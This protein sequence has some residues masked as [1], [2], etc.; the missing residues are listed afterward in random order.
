MLSKACQNAPGDWEDHLADVLYAHSISVSSTTGFSP[1][2]LLYGRRP[3]A[4]LKFL[5]HD[6]RGSHPLDNN[7]LMDMS[8]AWQ[9]AKKNSAESRRLNRERINQKANAGDLAV[10]DTVIVQ[11]LE[12]LTFTSKWD[13]Q[14][15]IIAISGSTCTVRHQQ[16]GQVKKLHR[17]KVKLVDPNL[18]WDTL[19]IRPK[20]TQNR[21]R[22]SKQ[23]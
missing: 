7:R 16:T 2:F 12:P 8:Y 5:V 4:P 9:I 11:A 10:G 17:E 18:L 23:T 3:R 1:F 13:P 14:Y 19:P 6:N 21:P 22:H 20:R 15:E